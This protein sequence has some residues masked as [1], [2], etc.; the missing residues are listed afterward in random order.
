MLTSSNTK[1]GAI[2]NAC[3]RL[4]RRAGARFCRE[5]CTHDE[6]HEQ[7]IDYFTMIR[8]SSPQI[9]HVLQTVLSNKIVEPPEQPELQTIQVNIKFVIMVADDQ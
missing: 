9:L 6:Q 7:N 5:K 2:K 8:R 1:K 3:T 4:S